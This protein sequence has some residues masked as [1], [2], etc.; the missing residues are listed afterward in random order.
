MYISLYNETYFKKSGDLDF[1]GDLVPFFF[2]KHP[3][4]RLKSDFFQ[5]KI[6]PKFANTNTETK[7]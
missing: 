4:N 1:L 5:V 2:M 3:L 6:C 7:W